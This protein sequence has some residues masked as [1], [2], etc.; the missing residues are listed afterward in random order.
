MGQLEKVSPDGV[1]EWSARSLAEQL[2]VGLQAAILVQ[3]APE[4]VALAFVESRLAER[5]QAVFGTLH[6][7]VDSVGVLDRAFKVL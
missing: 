6:S 3:T 5:P 1:S 2:A 4:E 7:G